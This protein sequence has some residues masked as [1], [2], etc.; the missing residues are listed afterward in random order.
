MRE[1]WEGGKWA[2]LLL[3]SSPE[4]LHFHSFLQQILL[5]PP[6]CAKPCQLSELF[7]VRCSLS[8]VRLILESGMC[9]QSTCGNTWSRSPV[10]PAHPAF[11]DSDGSMFV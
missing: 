8:Q 5:G 1:G 2:S 10:K 3:P 11:R 4:S 9:R 6:A 7:C